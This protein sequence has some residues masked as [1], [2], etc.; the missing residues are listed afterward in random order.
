MDIYRQPVEQEINGRSLKNRRS[1][2]TSIGISY[3][4]MI[5]LFISGSQ[6]HDY[7]Y[8][9]KIIK[10]THTLEPNISE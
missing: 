3:H 8:W 10:F 2:D 1:L 7:G 6:S 5:M 9:L 4:K